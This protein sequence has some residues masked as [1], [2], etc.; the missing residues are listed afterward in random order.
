MDGGH[1]AARL[2]RRRL[3]QLQVGRRARRPLSEEVQAGAQPGAGLRPQQLRAQIR[4]RSNPWKFP[5]SAIAHSLHYKV[6]HL[7]AEYCL[8]TSIQSSVTV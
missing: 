7:V 5:F 6:A 3:R 4:V 1:A 8:L 2:P